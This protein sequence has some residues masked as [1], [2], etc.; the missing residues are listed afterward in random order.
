MLGGAIFALAL[1]ACD[2]APSPAQEP[3][4]P[5][6]TFQI[7]SV[8]GSSQS[9]LLDTRSGATWYRVSTG[10]S[11]VDDVTEWIPMDRST[12]TDWNSLNRPAPAR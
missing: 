2:K 12:L 11:D 10:H 7:V 8:P 5:I 6:G 9:I 1:A 4:N 3:I